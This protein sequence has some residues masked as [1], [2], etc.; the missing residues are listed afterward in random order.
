MDLDASLKIFADRGGAEAGAIAERFWN[1]G[2]DAEFADYMRVCMPLYNRGARHDDADARRR[3]VMRME[4]YRRF[5]LAGGEIRTMDF[6]PVLSNIA[7]PLLV[8]GREH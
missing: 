6:R 8:L 7:C 4:G 5:S 3:A 1:F 2:T